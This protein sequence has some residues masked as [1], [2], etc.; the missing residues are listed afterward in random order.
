MA[1]ISTYGPDITLNNKDK[2]LGSSYVRTV[3]GVDE[4]ETKNFTLEEL[5]GFF[6]SEGSALSI[7]LKDNGGIVR[8][9]IDNTTKLAIDLGASSITGQLANADLANSSITINGTAISLGGTVTTPNTQLTDAQVRSKISVTGGGSYNSSTGVI[10]IPAGFTLAQGNVTNASVSG[11]TLTLTRQSTTDV[12]F[13]PTANDFTNT[14]KTKLDN[15]ESNATA[16]Q[17]AAEIRTLVEAATD[18]NVFTDDDHTK[19]NNIEANATADQTASEIKSLYE[20]NS[21]TNAFTDA[22]HTKLDNIEA[23]ATADQSDSE[24]KTAYENNSDTNAFTDALLSKLNG[25]EASATADQSNAEIRAAVEAATDSN[26]FTDNDHTKLDGIAAGAEVNVQ[27]NWNETTTTSDAFIQNKPT[28]FSGDYDDLTNKPTLLQLGTTSTTALAGNTSLLQ[29][30]TTSTTAL[31]GNTTTISSTQAANITTNNA[32]TSFPG[33]GT[34]SG[35]ALE[36]DT[37]LFSGD[38]DDLSNKPTI[39]SGNQ[40]IDWTTDQGSTNIHTGNYNNTQL[41][42]AQVRSKISGSGLISYDSS[43]GEITT[44]ANNYTLP[45]ATS[46]ARGGIKIGY[47]TDG[48]ARNYAIQLSSEKGYV[49]VPWTD[50][51]YTLPTASSSTLGGVKVGGNLT[52]DSNGVLDVGAIA[53][54]TVQAAANETAHLNLT[55]QEGDIVVRSDQNKS[56]VHNG[57]SA[58]TMAD[59]T[60]LL[61]PTD[62][63]LSVTTTDG[64]YIDLTPNTAATGAITI[65]ADLSAEAVSGNIDNTKFLRGDNKWAVPSYTTDLDHDTLTNYVANEHIDWTTDQ[66]STNIHTGNYNNT[67]LSDAEVITAIVNSD[68]I[69]N[70][71]KGTIRS[72]IGAGTS[73]LALGTT[74]TTALAG[75]TALFDGD[76]DSLTNKPTIP[77]GNAIIDW[78]ADQ[79]NTNI[80]VN[81]YNN[82]QLSDSEVVAAIVASTSI[83]ATDKGTFRT[84]IGAGTSSFD[85]DYDSLSNTP[86]IPSGNAI[87]DWTTD[88][89][90]T[91][92]H[93]G[94]YINTVD[95]G[96]G[97]KIANAAGT[98]QFT[99]IED[100][101]I[102][103]AAS[104]AASVSFNASDQKVTI[105]ATNTTYTAGHGLTLDGT[106]FQWNYGIETTSVTAAVNNVSTTAG[107]YYAVQADDQDRPELVVNVPWT[108]NNTTY[109]AGNGMSLSGTAFSADINYISYNGSNNFIEHGTQNEEGNTIPTGGV[110]VYLGT[111]NNKIVERATVGDLPFLSS[112][113]GTVSGDLSL[114]GHISL[115]DNKY[116]KLGTGTDFLARHDGTD[117]TF[118]NSTGDYYI[119][120]QA[121][122]KDLYLGINDSSTVRNLIMLDGST[123]QIKLLE[124]TLIQDGSGN[125]DLYLGNIIGPSSSDKGARFHSNNSDFYMDFQ[126]DSTQNWFLRDYDGSGGTH[127]RF[128][129]DFV[130]A[131]FTAGGDVV[132]FGSPSDKTLKENIK[133]IDNAL[134]KV[135]KL[136]GVTFDWKE[137]DITNLKEDIGFI[138]QDV[139]E[140]LPELV[141][142]NE[143]GKLSLRHQGIIPV[144]LEAIKEL[145]DKVKALENGSTK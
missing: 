50:T 101:E 67:Q 133:P 75:N 31:A 32:K 131:K 108:D 72:N 14:L 89:G 128:A 18:S 21:D 12:T 74:E 36:G 45:L 52:I 59:Y 13:T 41:T 22:D 110:L 33:F 118:V 79:G 137:Q 15:I 122:D 65:T 46:S 109:T 103:F 112:S 68:A 81:N 78:T 92:I 56:Y 80:H 27:A 43:T 113:G 95:M 82:T 120:N 83:S 20:G 85:G 42:D 63:V 19:L 144:L 26:V 53:L 40:I 93:S 136:Q 48:S 3:S 47:T 132:A 71:N 30:G 90:S 62:A 105:G 87:I 7:S 69:T 84:N 100:E 51:V 54:T 116:I 139:K 142:E 1:K 28:L 23:N 2:V 64:T 24:I 102:R 125:A 127:T 97:F 86:T 114:T 16:D 145:S 73:N 35:K 77:S 141:R 107:R 25:I 8:E 130:N 61:T 119:Q 111:S 98:D 55:A 44:T 135:E 9:T 91:N 49:N 123:S 29:L 117:T 99:V 38:Y 5:N 57:G 138:A 143:N 34:T 76:Y 129:F 106:E 37:S 94:N 140:V 66:G 4:F 17:T 88:Q 124:T 39:P 104:G 126:G 60:L 134:D 115:L 58:G 11:Q 70:A 6:T 10:T 96:S 121:V